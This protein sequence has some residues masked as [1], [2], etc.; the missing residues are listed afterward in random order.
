MTVD[1]RALKQ[2]DKQKG[3]TNRSGTLPKKYK[4]SDYLI[5]VNLI[6]KRFY[7]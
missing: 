2:K 5:R 1:V 6:V 7:I 4:N 3:C